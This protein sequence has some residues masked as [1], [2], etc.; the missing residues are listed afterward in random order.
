MNTKSVEDAFYFTSKIYKD[1][2]LSKIKHCIWKLTAV[3]PPVIR[4]EPTASLVVKGRSTEL[5]CEA[6]GNPPITY[7]WFKVSI[8]RL[9]FDLT[10]HAVEINPL[11]AEVSNW[12]HSAIH[13]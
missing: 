2:L 4:R 7:E 5:S 10:L 3:D 13:I 9:L 8:R 6:D 12:L 1:A 11:K